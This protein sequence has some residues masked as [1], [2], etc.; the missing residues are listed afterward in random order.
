MKEVYLNDLGLIGFST[1]EVLRFD[2]FDH[3][4]SK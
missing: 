1:S 3:S 2:N 4:L